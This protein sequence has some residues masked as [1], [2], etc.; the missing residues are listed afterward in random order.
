V[1]GEVAELGSPT[2]TVTRNA[3]G[4]T[5]VKITPTKSRFKDPSGVWRDLD[6]TVVPH[7]DGSLGAKAAD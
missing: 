5:T 7:P 1:V 6:L 3:D 4:T 2:R